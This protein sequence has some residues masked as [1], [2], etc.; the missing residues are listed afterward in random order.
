MGSTRFGSVCC[1]CFSFAP[2]CFCLYSSGVGS[3]TICRPLRGVPVPC[4]LLC[5]SPAWASVCSSLGQA[6]SLVPPFFPASSCLHLCPALA[7]LSSALV[8]LAPT[9]LVSH[10]QML[11]VLCIFFIIFFSLHSRLGFEC[12]Y[13]L[14]YKTC[15]GAHVE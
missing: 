3:S 4:L 5:I 6:T 14:H 7:S 12:T 2:P 9:F 8:S 1:V 13:T 15:R 10:L 11:T